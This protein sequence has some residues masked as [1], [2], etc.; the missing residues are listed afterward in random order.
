MRPRL[1]PAA[2]ALVVVVAR[3]LWDGCL[4]YSPVNV[5]TQAVATG[6]DQVAERL[7]TRLVHDVGIEVK[8]NGLA[9]SDL[10]PIRPERFSA[11]EDRARL[12]IRH[13]NVNVGV[14]VS[15]A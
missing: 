14:G 15:L 9:D 2:A 5:L 4:F 10:E 13:F 8:D 12:W 7:Q 3:V 11:G 6:E 1:A